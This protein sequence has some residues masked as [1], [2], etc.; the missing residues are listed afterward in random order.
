MKFDID[1]RPGHEDHE[2]REEI[3]TKMKTKKLQMENEDK[4]LQMNNEN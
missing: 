2:D 4:K 1:I 3:K